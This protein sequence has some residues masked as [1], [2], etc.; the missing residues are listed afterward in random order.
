MK[1]NH[2]TVFTHYIAQ[3]QKLD[4]PTARLIQ[5]CYSAP[6]YERFS[7]DERTTSD[8]KTGV[9]LAH[10]IRLSMMMFSVILVFE[11]ASR[12]K[13][14]YSRE[15][16]RELSTFSPITFQELRSTRVEEKIWAIVRN[17]WF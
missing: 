15:F 16:Y 17:Q 8:K 9:S 10:Y 2:R 1:N 11:A 5:Y 3:G 13:Q 7:D 4:E 12:L 6:A 14:H